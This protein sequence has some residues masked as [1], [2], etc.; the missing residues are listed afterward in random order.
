MS[1]ATPHHHDQEHGAAGESSHI[2]T[3]ISAN[4]LHRIPFLAAL[5]PDL[6]IKDD[7]PTRGLGVA[8]VHLQMSERAYAQHIAG[9]VIENDTVEQLDYQDLVKNDKC[10]D[11]WIK[12][13]TNE[14]DRLAQGVR[15]IK[16]TDTIFVVLKY[17]IPKNRIKEVTY[18]RIVVAYKPNKSEP[19]R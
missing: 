14:L 8:N 3:K 19:H 6:T 10:R 13:L 1:K 16:G 15:D 5:N 12:S 17:A 9:A 11:T 4:K 18:G 7:R 2:N